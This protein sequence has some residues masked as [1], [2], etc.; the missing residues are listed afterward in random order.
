MPPNGARPRA[1]AAERKATASPTPSTNGPVAV[2]AGAG[3]TAERYRRLPTGAHGL[4]REEV[5][6]D[7]RERLQRAMTELIAERGYQAVRI[8][9]ITKLA[10]V[11]RPTF[12]ELYADKEDLLLSA[13]NAIAGRTAQA[14]LQAFGQRG[15]L[16]QRLRAG[17]HAFA[18]LAQSDPEAM[19]L[20][21]MG[22]FGA[23]PRALARRK[24]TVTAL[25]TGIQTR[26]DGTLE[27]NPGDLT[28]KV[29]LGGIRELAVARLH[30]G[31]TQELDEIADELIAWILCYPPNLLPALQCPAA[32]VEEDAADRE[33]T[34]RFASERAR[35]AHGRLPSGRHDL[36]REVVVNSQRERIMDATAEVVAEKGL[37]ALTIP[38]IA[39]RASVSHETFYEMFE[40]KFSAFLATQRAGMEQAFGRGVGAYEQLMPDWPR[41]IA[42][43][44]RGVVDFVVSEPAH[45]HLTFV[46]AFGASPETI[47]VRDEILRG[48]ASYVGQG[49]E[50]APE[51]VRVPAV[52]A[53][54]VVGGCWQVLYHY[55]DDD[56]VNE[57]P[58]ATPQLVYMLLC[59]FLGAKEAGRVAVASADDEEIAQAV[60]QTASSSLSFAQSA[61]PPAPAASAAPAA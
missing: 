12:Y 44:M 56:R 27:P 23:G 58:A 50:R 31:R 22:A 26:R 48:F 1:R 34:G 28:V 3:G 5:E 25:E 51:G 60:A 11:S 46:D 2:G 9:D 39:S 6:R 36:P 7:Q 30:E 4:A 14:V 29:Q 24:E 47:A 20:F 13:Y 19:S 40:T 57:L 43:G 42:A 55:I 16:E 37:A 61:P 21:L 52:S 8:L 17:M 18:R 54:A 33:L 49:F 45:A 53:E 38:E 10:H 59:P 35:R 41:A 15:D 32:E